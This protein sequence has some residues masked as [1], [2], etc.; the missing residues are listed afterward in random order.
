MF[1]HLIYYDF[2]LINQKP[3]FTISLEAVEQGSSPQTSQV[4]QVT[5][6]TNAAAGQQQPQQPQKNEKKHITD[7]PQKNRMIFGK[8]TSINAVFFASILLS[9][10]LDKNSQVFTLL[11][12]SLCIFGFIPIF[13]HILRHRLRFVYDISALISTFVLGYCIFQMHRFFGILYFS[14]IVFISFLS[15]LIFIYAYQFKNDIRGPWDCPTI[16]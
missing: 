13:R 1:I 8:P 11:Y 12:I 14:L 16:K 5:D 2:D 7:V 3:E 10:R 4:Q 9:S 6:S 15:P